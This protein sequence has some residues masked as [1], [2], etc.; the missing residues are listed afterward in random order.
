MSASRVIHT[1]TN[2]YFPYVP[3]TDSINFE[4]PIIGQD[5]GQGAE[6]SNIKRPEIRKTVIYIK[7]HLNCNLSLR[8]IADSV[9]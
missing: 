1:L 6:L 4:P 2:C 3:K 8:T 7:E 5:L 9:F